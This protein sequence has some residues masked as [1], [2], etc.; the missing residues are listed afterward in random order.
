[1]AIT[2]VSIGTI[3]ESA[4]ATSIT[5]SLPASLATGDYVVFAVTVPCT[6]TAT[7]TTEPLQTI[8][9]WTKLAGWKFVNDTNAVAIFGRFKDAS[10]STMPSV[11]TSH[12]ASRTAAI[13]V[14]YR[15]LD[16]TTPVDAA[17]VFSGT[18]TAGSGGTSLAMTGVT[19]V[20][21]GAMLLSACVIDSSTDVFSPTA[22]SGMTFLA[23][24]TG[25]ADGVAGRGLSVA[26][27]SRATA[28][29]TG[30]RTWTHGTSVGQGGYVL[31]LRPSTG[32][33][34]TGSVTATGALTRS[35]AKRLVASITAAGAAIKKTTKNAFPNTI[36]ASGVLTKRVPKIFTA[37]STATG[38]FTKTRVALANFAGSIT[39]AG[40]FAHNNIVKL[41]SGSVTAVGVAIKRTT[42]AARTGSITATGA[43][44]KTTPKVFT[45]S[46]TATG[47]L[48]KVLA[49]IWG[50]SITATGIAL[51]TT[52][53]TPIGSISSTGAFVKVPRKILTGSS[54]ATGFLIKGLSRV[55]VA[56]IVTAGIAIKKTT[57]NAFTGS[58]TPTGFY[59]KSF[60]RKFAGSITPT[61]SAIVTFLGRFFGRPGEAV[62]TVVQDSEAIIRIP[63]N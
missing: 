40:V 58:T 47:F 49:R 32:P 28:G 42:L 39:A 48:R 16:S 37:S 6:S 2:R 18:T 11:T 34:F 52:M 7:E 14:A 59:R 35:P 23:T 38:A 53:K 36:T 17:A 54:T 21:A 60:I 57:K 43:L 55:F 13:S 1:M 56:A 4:S 20:T 26:E 10:W 51:K 61:S 50:S 3:V 24:T 5:P 19:T 15:G 33:V 27:E 62:V 29:A 30:T 25:T 22:P 46:V 45:A 44:V 12:A 9:G 41:L 31:A 63:N 8:T